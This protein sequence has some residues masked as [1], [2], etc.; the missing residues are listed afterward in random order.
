MT[1]GIA[2]VLKLP[3]RTC[4]CVFICYTKCTASGASRDPCSNTFCGSGPSSEAENKAVAAE[5]ARVASSLGAYISLHAP[6]CTWMHPWG[7]LTNSSGVH[8]D[9]CEIAE[10]EAEMVRSPR[11]YST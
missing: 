2:V 10:D 5:S 1:R 3:I 6:A 11:I 4:V 9:D 8:P 7:T